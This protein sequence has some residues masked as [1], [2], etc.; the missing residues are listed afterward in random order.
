M[1]G[2]RFICPGKPV[3]QRITLQIVGFYPKYRHLINRPEGL[4]FILSG[5][6][7]SPQIKM[8]LRY[9]AKVSGSK[10]LLAPYVPTGSNMRDICSCTT[11]HTE[12]I[13]RGQICQF[14]VRWIIATK[15][16]LIS[17]CLFDAIVSTKK[18]TK[19]FKNFCPSL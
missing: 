15:G 14:Y 8:G 17:K 18:P 3:N 2:R 13:H 19:F 10:T 9:L 4:I 7:L 12:V 16:Q 11:R 5:D 1:L 6:I